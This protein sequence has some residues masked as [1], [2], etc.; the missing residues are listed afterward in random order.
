MRFLTII[1]ALSSLTVQASNW[2]VTPSGGG[3]HNGSTW[4]QAFA[5]SLGIN[6]SSVQ[7]GDTVWFSGGT[8]ANFQWL[9][10]GTI[11]AR[12][13]MKR[14]T[15][16][17]PECTG[18]PGWQP[19]FDSQVLINVPYPP[20]G[21]NGYAGIRLAPPF[22]D[23]VTIDGQVPNGIRFKLATPTDNWATTTTKQ[24][25][26][27]LASGN[28]NIISY[29]EI[30]G[31]G[32][33][34]GWGLGVGDANL[35]GVKSGCWIHHCYIH[36]S[37]TAMQLQDNTVWLIENNELGYTPGN[38]YN[39]ENS[40]YVSNAQW[41]IFRNNYVHAFSALGL[42]FTALTPPGCNHWKVY[43]NVFDNS[44]YSNQALNFDANSYNYPNGPY[45]LGSDWQIYNNTFINC[46][47]A[48]RT[49]SR[50]PQLYNSAVTGGLIEN[51]LIFNSA[52][53]P[54]AMT[55]DYN[56]TDRS[57][58]FG[59][60]HGIVYGNQPFV[61]LAGHDYHIV[62]TIGATYPR[63]K[64]VA[65]LPEVSPD[66]D[67]VAR[68]S[69]PS[70]GAYEYAGAGPAPPPAVPGVLAW[71]S[72]SYSAS[73]TGG[74]ISLTV[75]RTVGSDGIVGAS[76]SFVNG[77]AI[78]GHDFTGAPGTVSLGNGVTTATVVVPILNSGDTDTSA[79]TFG[80][81]LSSPTGG[82]SLGPISA[83]TV[84]ITMTPPP[85]PPA[86]GLASLPT[87]TMDQGVLT[88]PFYITNTTVLYNP[89][90][91]DGTGLATYTLFITNAGVYWLSSS[92]NA[93]D[94]GHNSWRVDFNQDP[95]MDDLRC[96]DITN[97]TI[98]FES[99]VVGWRGNGTFAYDQF[100]TNYWTLSAG[101]NTLYIR[102]RGEPGQIASMTLH[103]VTPPPPPPYA[104]LAWDTPGPLVYETADLFTF[105]LLRSGD[106]TNVTTVDYSTV[107]G[108]A[109]AGVNYVPASGT[110]TFASGVASVPL[111]LHVLYT[112]IYEGNTYYTV[113][114]TNASVNATILTTNLLVT[115]LEPAPAPT[116][117]TN[118][119]NNVLLNNVLFP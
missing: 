89:S 81:V 95:G 99:R 2:F 23:Y 59:E 117:K 94:G 105:H 5:G 25:Y 50:W 112:P 31:P 42:Y 114:L 79:R 63:G 19:S 111:T 16:S 36:D 77:S 20:A 83:T 103:Q 37:S 55:H 24:Y 76:Y 29:I 40:A 35:F 74:S 53:G 10:A 38:F 98:G 18:S 32:V 84:S 22:S 90:T 3:S 104:F 75:S 60:P 43:G 110:L 100:P 113:V 48:I 34:A 6:W 78:A 44:P 92:V 85:P 73:E 26:G 109:K 72:P 30:E 86:P 51:N 52:F 107:A 106:T 13:A 41:G 69:P 33:P 9:K 8:Y 58:L 118:V 108:T 67:G 1:L 116:L 28:S 102:G 15:A 82:A 87:F 62:S 80:V 56:Y 66:K 97:F 70:I 64:G 39:H 91:V 54:G 119:L 101:T 47:Q 71:S 93:P 61:N 11:G 14:A 21:Q 17:N 12:V 7:P 115:V 49:D 96:W 88:F 46:L 45:Q 68:T 4:N 65:T 57:T 27:V